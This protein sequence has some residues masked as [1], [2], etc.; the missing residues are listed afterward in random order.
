MISSPTQGTFEGYVLRKRIL[1]FLK[2]DLEYRLERRTY[3]GFEKEYEK[4]G[5]AIVEQHIH[6]TPE[7]TQLL[8]QLLQEMEN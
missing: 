4:K 8:F 6:L 3:S 2:G 5:R 1:P 7:E